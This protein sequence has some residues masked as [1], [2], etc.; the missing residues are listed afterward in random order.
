MA[1]AVTIN[2][3]RTTVTGTVASFTPTAQ[4]VLTTGPI[5][6]AAPTSPG[7]SKSATS[8]GSDKTLTIGISVAMSGLVVIIIVLGALLWRSRRKRNAKIEKDRKEEDAI[9]ETLKRKMMTSSP[10]S[11]RDSSQP[12][13]DGQ[14][15]SEIEG[16]ERTELDSRKLP[17][18]YK[19]G[20]TY[21]ELHEDERRI[22][23]DGRQQTPVEMPGDGPE[24]WHERKVRPSSIVET[25]SEGIS[26]RNPFEDCSTPSSPTAPL[27]TA[28]TEKR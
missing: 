18:G 20:T 13:L 5:A 9:N 24:A 12:E 8:S 23:L 26:T 16:R 22:E 2:G 15:R 17:P 7:A 28:S 19:S 1:T 25:P 4:P 27:P 21:A 6:E 3:V 14:K 11:S 10:R